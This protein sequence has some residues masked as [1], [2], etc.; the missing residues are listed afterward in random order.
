MLDERAQPS[1]P[2]GGLGSASHTAAVKLRLDLMAQFGG[3]VTNAL[4]RA[5]TRHGRLHPG[6][7]PTIEGP[8]VNSEKSQLTP[9]DEL[10][11]MMES[12]GASDCGSPYL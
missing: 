9:P 11:R 1:G 8:T 4:L 10:A 7:A 3:A 12:R 2:I 6:L 5:M